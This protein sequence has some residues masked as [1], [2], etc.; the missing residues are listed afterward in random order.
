MTMTR[1]SDLAHAFAVMVL[2]AIVS[3]GCQAIAVHDARSLL[4]PH[5]QK[6]EIWGFIAGCGTTFAAVPD[7]ITMFRRRSSEGMHPRLAAILA[8]FQ[9]A[10]IYYGLLID[11]RPVIAWNAIAVVINSLNVVAIIYFVHSRSKNA[12][13]RSPT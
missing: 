12:S 7:M 8:I 2:V 13:P 1:P 6:S 5:L 3:A 4:S 11:S 10:W 9:V